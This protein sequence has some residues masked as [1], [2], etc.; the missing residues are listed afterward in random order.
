MN[1]ISRPDAVA[2]GLKRYFT[3]DPC[4][5]G[6]VSS[7]YVNGRNCTACQQEL[8]TRRRKE[9]P[10]KAKEIQRIW[11]AENLEKARGYQRKY[12][13][14]HLERRR[15]LNREFMRNNRERYIEKRRARFQKINDLIA[16]LRDVCPEII[17]E[18]GL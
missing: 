9:D 1:I 17:Q 15:A 8:V 2:Q 4:R 18:F 11:Y 13:L 3:G 12:M 5:H 14:K 16:V 10:E 6:H 7:R